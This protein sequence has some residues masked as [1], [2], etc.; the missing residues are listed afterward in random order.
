MNLRFDMDARLPRRAT[1]FFLLCTKGPAVLDA[2][3]PRRRARLAQQHQL[4]RGVHKMFSFLTVFVL[5]RNVM[6]CGIDFEVYK[7]C[8]Q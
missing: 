4:H 1:S 8:L 5:R 6:T 3:K 7:Y 2:A